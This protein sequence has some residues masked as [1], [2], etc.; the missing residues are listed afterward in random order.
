MAL[1]KLAKNPY[2]NEVAAVIRREGTSDRYQ[3]I[4]FN[5]DLGLYQEYLEWVNAG[6]TP[7]PAD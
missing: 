3:F 6:N 7:D 1:Y 5:E 4:P 2:T